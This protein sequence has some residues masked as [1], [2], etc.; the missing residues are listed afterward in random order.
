MAELNLAQ[1]LDVLDRRAR[2]VRMAIFAYIIISV[3]DMLV[4]LAEAFG[5]VDTNAEELSPLA[6]AA[7]LAHLLA[8]VALIAAVVLVAMWIY[9]AHANLR[10][11]GLS[12][13]EFTPGWA[14]GWYFIPLA[15]LFKPFQAM[16]ELWNMSLLQNDGFGQEADSRLTTWWGAWIVGNILSNIGFRLQSMGGSGAA[17]IGYALDIVSTAAFIAAGWFL[18]RIIE[19]ISTAQRGGTTMATTFA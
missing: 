17:T 5:V 12:D 6:L 1:G 14:V 9:R 7:S 8:V 18:W 3:A 4:V 19:T 13:L 11:A 16:R 15:N 10:E 2:T